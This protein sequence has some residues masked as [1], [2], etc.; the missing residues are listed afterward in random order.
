MSKVN[1]ASNSLLC[2][3]VCRFMLKKSKPDFSTSN[4]SARLSE[5]VMADERDDYDLLM[6]TCSVRSNN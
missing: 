5:E 2:V 6:Q 1:A 4:S 3:C